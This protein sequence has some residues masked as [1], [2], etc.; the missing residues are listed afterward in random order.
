MI[1]DEA[2]ILRERMTTGQ[3]PRERLQLA[4]SLGYTVAQTALQRPDKPPPGPWDPPEG[5]PTLE[6][7][8]RRLARFGPT[9]MVRIAVAV[10]RYV[11]STV[12]AHSALDSGLEAAD[13]FLARAEGGS[14][15]ALQGP[16]DLAAKDLARTALKLETS[17][18]AQAQACLTLL[19]VLRAILAILEGG[20]TDRALLDGHYLRTLEQA[21]AA[22]L[23]L[24]EVQAGVR[25]E[26]CAW[27]LA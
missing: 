18:P 6:F 9:V 10:A 15:E 22:E 25:A 23:P 24:E 2:T 26:V 12:D 11:T 21:S 4:D 27:A 16:C 3:L 5:E 17:S 14:G 19:P 20:P 8:G 13:A 7:W 1:Q